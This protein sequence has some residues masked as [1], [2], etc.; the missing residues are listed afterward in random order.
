M[1]SLREEAGA[2]ATGLEQDDEE[3][4][5]KDCSGNDCVM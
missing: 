1:G 4:Q 2:A 3:E 5:V